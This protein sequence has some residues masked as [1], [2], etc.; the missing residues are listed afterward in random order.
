MTG[1][2]PG[3]RPRPDLGTGRSVLGIPV[4]QLGTVGVVGLFVWAVGLW[5]AHLNG[6][7]VGLYLDAPP[8]KGTWRTGFTTL[9][10][11]FLYLP[12]LVS[13]ALIAVAV[14][15]WWS[16]AVARL[17]FR[18]VL[19]GS[20]AWSLAWTS[21]VA[22]TSSPPSL[23]R[24]LLDRDH[25]YL[26]FARELRSPSEFVSGFLENIDRYPTHV[27]GHPPGAVLAFWG[28]DRL[29]PSDTLFGLGLLALAATAAPASLIAVRSVADEASARRAAVFAGLAPAVVWIGT[30]ADALVMATIAWAVALGFI[31]ATARSEGEASGGSAGPQQ[32]W[33]VLLPAAGAGLLA[34]A[35]VALSFGSAVLLAPVGAAVVLLAMR[36]RLA[37]VATMVACSAVAPLGLTLM[38]YDWFDGYTALREQYWAGVASERPQ[39][40]FAFSNLAAFAVALGPAAVAGV[41]TLRDR[42]VWWLPGSALVGIALADLSAMSKGEVERIWLPAVPWVVVATASIRTLRTRRFWVAVTM[43]FTVL[44]QWKL[45]PAW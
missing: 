28:L 43:G 30:S 27:R 10:W 38:G 17:R 33:R 44:V 21:A 12:A 39:W 26:V 23:T 31:S 11:P 20:W 34:G 8:F 14:T 45:R 29:L 32:R 18:S 2:D 7:D 9:E 36:R 13:V 16:D 37:G 22:L 1:T 5:G 4:A 35:A 40:Y 3:A 42:R 24:P 25:E 19:A 41:A 15:L 6:T